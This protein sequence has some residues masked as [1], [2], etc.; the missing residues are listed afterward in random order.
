MGLRSIALRQ[1]HADAFVCIPC[2][3]RSNRR[4]HSCKRLTRDAF[5]VLLSG[6]LQ[7]LHSRSPR[8]PQGSNPSHCRHGESF[9]QIMQ[10]LLCFSRQS[11]SK[12]PLNDPLGK[13]VG[14]RLIACIRKQV[15]KQFATW[16][17]TALL[18]YQICLLTQSKKNLCPMYFPQP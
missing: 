4:D 14:G 3:E 2:P 16:Y 10:A 1:R 11:V 7:H 9:F 18:T 12:Q 17:S 6:D 15:N 5:T 8:V 13:H